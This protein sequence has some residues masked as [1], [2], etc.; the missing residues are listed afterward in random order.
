MENGYKNAFVSSMDLFSKNNEPIKRIEIY[1][2]NV[3]VLRLYQTFE[4]MG[5]IQIP[6]FHV[7]YSVNNIRT[8]I[9]N[10]I[11][12]K[13][14]IDISYNALKYFENHP[15]HTVIDEKDLITKIKHNRGIMKRLYEKHLKT[16]NRFIKPLENQK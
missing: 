7:F 10:P 6:T 14:A 13:R 8:K 1:L 9:Q 2:A 12:K 4:D 3:G 15:E 5:D 11:L 16:Y